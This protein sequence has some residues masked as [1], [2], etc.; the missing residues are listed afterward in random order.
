MR[1]RVVRKRVVRK[2]PV[3]KKTTRK[4]VVRKRMTMKVLP[5]RRLVWK[6]PKGR[7]QR[8]PGGVVTPQKRPV[9]RKALKSDPAPSARKARSREQ[10]KKDA[11]NARARLVKEKREES[12]WGALLKDKRIQI[13]IKKSEEK[14]TPLWKKLVP[15]AK[16]FAGHVPILGDGLRLFDD[17]K[18]GH[19]VIKGFIS[20][21]PEVDPM[22]RFRR[23]NLQ[24]PASA[25]KKIMAEAVK[26]G[27]KHEL[28]ASG[29]G[30][31]RRAPQMLIGDYDKRVKHEDV[32]AMITNQQ[33]DDISL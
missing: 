9:K 29:R 33:D 10:T 27:K 2:R 13:E 30:T 5:K 11:A 26:E 6:R 8:L 31:K 18:L 21:T 3:R 28:H 14:N 20:K 1:K 22:L 25:M 4:R 24:I 12:D 16:R 7:L 32:P 19:D 15:V 23:N 17:I